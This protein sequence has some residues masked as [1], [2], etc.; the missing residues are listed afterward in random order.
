MR[1]RFW[2]LAMDMLAWLHRRT[3]RRWRWPFHAYLYALGK[4]ADM[5]DWGD[6]RRSTPAP[7]PGGKV[8]P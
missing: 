8:E 1:L 5:T 6:W 3:R 4:A 2:L 7:P